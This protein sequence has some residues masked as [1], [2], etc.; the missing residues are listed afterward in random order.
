MNEIPF[1][2]SQEYTVSVF[3]HRLGIKRNDKIHCPK[4]PKG[5]DEGWFLTL[6]SQSDGE[7]LALK[8]IAY[9]SNKSSHQILFNAPRKLGR[10][11]YTLYLISDGY[12]GFDQQYDIQFDVIEPLSQENIEAGDDY[13]HSIIAEG[14]KL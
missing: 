11:I 10:V 13:I 1:L 5:K 6:G 8:R 12:I 2:L 3:L 9:R 7:L 14:K 4:F